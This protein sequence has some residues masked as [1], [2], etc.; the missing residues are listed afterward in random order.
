VGSKLLEVWN[1]WNE[2]MLWGA[3]RD[4]RYIPNISSVDPCVLVII[5]VVVISTVVMEMCC[6]NATPF[7]T[8]VGALG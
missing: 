4:S 7:S 5:N 8:F 2:E 1:G 6:V 3:L